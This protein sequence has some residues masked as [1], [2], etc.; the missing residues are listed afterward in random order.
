MLRTILV[1]LF[2]AVAIGGTASAQGLGFEEQF[3]L[4]EDR[5][6]LLEQLVPGTEEH[7]Y[8]TC[9]H[10]QQTGRTD[11]V[12]EL[13]QAW[14]SRYG[15]TKRFETIEMRQ[16]LLDYS[17]RPQSVL[18]ELRNRLGYSYDHTAIDPERPPVFPSKLD[19][20]TIEAGS[21]LEQELARHPN[22]VEGFTDRGLW[23]LATRRMSPQL[24][25][26]LLA[27]LMW[28]DY[29]ELVAL[30]V[31]DLK[32][33]NSPGFGSLQ[34]HG[35]LTLDQLDAAASLMPD[36]LHN[37]GFVATYLA[38]LAP[39]AG[40]D[41]RSDPIAERAYL[42]RLATFTARL[43]PSLSGLRAHALY[44][45]LDFERRSGR[46]D[47]ELLLDYLKLP[48]RADYRNPDYLKRREFGQHRTALEA[49]HEGLLEPVSNDWSLVRDCL[50]HFL[51]DD[52]GPQ[53]FAE[54]IREPI[55]RG[56]FVEA[57]VTAGSGDLER[58]YTLL[59][60]PSAFE[61]LKQRV[62]LDF[63]PS[64]RRVFRSNESVTLDLDLK[65]V[66][67]L[68]VKVY[69]INALNYYRQL[70]RELDPTISLDGLVPN[71]ERV[72][73]Y[74]EPSW[75]RVRRH[76][77]FPELAQ[78]G[79]YVIDFIGNGV[80]SRA[81]IQKGR[82]R[83]FER[84]GGAGHVFRVYD[85]LGTPVTNA[86]LWV[87]G[88]EYVANDVGDVVVPYT[89]QPGTQAI[90]A[91]RG[92]GPTALA[93]LGSF[94]HEEEE[95]SLDVDFHLDPE[96]LITDHA[97]PLLVRTRL[98]VH[99]A[100]VS[101]ERLENVQL[102]IEV[103]DLDKVSTTQ[104]IRDFELTDDELSVQTLRVPPRTTTVKV[105]LEG[106]IQSLTLGKSV[107]VN[108]HE[109]FHI[110]GIDTTAEI[111][112][113][114]FGRGPSGYR[115]E[116]RGKTGEPQ[117][118]VTVTVHLSQ[119]DI[120]KPVSVVLQSDALGFVELGE[121]LG[122]TEV[123]A[124]VPTGSASDGVWRLEDSIVTLPSTLH[125]RTA[126]VIRIPYVGRASTVS[127]IDFA[128]FELRGD[129]SPCRDQLDR[130]RLSGA[131]L[132][133]RDL[134]PGD[135]RLVMK[136]R[137]QGVLLRITDAPRTDRF[138]LSEA[139]GLE[140]SRTNA[141]QLADLSATAA[142]VV[143]QVAHPSPRTRV[144]LVARRFGHH[145]TLGR[146]LWSEVSNPEA[147][148][149]PLPESSYLTGRE[150]GDELRYILDRRRATRYP[151]NLL[152][153]PG[154]LLN[155]W[156]LRE[157]VTGRTE[158][159]AG[160]RWRQPP[161]GAKTGE[162]ER[163]IFY[164]SES[165]ARGG[166]RFSP[167]HD[168]LPEPS[169]VV[170]N[171][172]PGTDGAVRIPRSRLGTHRLVNAVVV[173]GASVIE[174]QLWLEDKPWSPKD[175]T[176]A[177]S[178]DP[179]ERFT[180]RKRI[181]AVRAGEALRIERASSAAFEIYPDLASVYRLYLTLS[182]NSTL[183][184]FSF[185]LDWPN[186][187]DDEKRAL[188]SR[189]ACHELN[190]FLW[191]KD[192]GFFTSV[193]LPTLE[194]K[195]DPTFLDRFFLGNDLTAFLDPWAY[196]Q[197]NALERAL[198]ASR[199]PGES[200]VTARHLRDLYELEPIPPQ[201]WL[202]RFRTGLQ[203][204]ALDPSQGTGYVEDS[205]VLGFGQDGTVAM[206]EEAPEGRMRRALVAPPQSPALAAKPP[207]ASAA[208]DEAD[209]ADKDLAYSKEVVR[210]YRKTPPTR[211][212]AESNY[213]HVR[214]DGAGLELI[215]ANAFWV[216]YAAHRSS[217]GP[218]LSENLAEPTGS[219]TEMLCALAVLDLPFVGARSA[220]SAVDGV[221][222]IEPTTGFVAFCQEIAPTKSTS[223]APILVGQ[224]LFRLDDRYR[225]EGSE[226]RDKFVT[227]EFIINTVYGCQVVV[228]NP[229][230]S[231]QRLDLLLQI[232]QG[233]L[234]A[235]S[236]FFTGGRFLELAPYAT[237]RV[238]YHFYFPR[239]GTFS[240]Y[241]IHVSQQGDFVTAA[242]GR[243]LNV[244]AKATQVDTD[245]WSHIS[246]QGSP[247]QV[248]RYLE[249]NNLERTDLDLIAWRLRDTASY[250]T[251]GS[252]LLELLK[253]R[254]R[255]EDSL[256]A[257]SLLHN[258]L[259]TAREFLRHEEVVLD[260]CGSWFESDLVTTN[261]V[262]QRLYEHLEYDPLVNA[263]A[264][265]LGGTRTIDNAAFFE[266][267]QRFLKQLGQKRVAADDDRLAATYYLLLQDRVDDA[268]REFALVDRERVAT[269]VQYDYVS[270]YLALFSTDAEA[271][272]AVALRHA[273]HPLVPWRERFRN[274]IDYLDEVQNVGSTQRSGRGA[275]LETNADLAE[276]EPTF[277]LRVQGQQIAIDY[278]NLS[279]CRVNYY[280]MDV[281]L[282]FSA[283]PFA[284]DSSASTDGLDPWAAIRPALSTFVELPTDRASFEFTVPAQFETSNVVVEVVAAGKRRAQARYS[285]RMSVQLAERYGQLR[286][287]RADSGSPLPS[288][289]VKVYS[290][291]SSGA[292][293]F[294]KDGYTDL[295][296]RFDYASL[297]VDELDDVQRFSILV[298]N[299]TEGAL[300]QV[301][302][303]PKQ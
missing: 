161:S 198:L 202:R 66:P 256:W 215:P 219:F 203:G 288:T 170:A 94:E 80:G 242:G 184:E 124:V 85:D 243:T 246:Q 159:K 201:D 1:M 182:S 136:E 224:N 50:L 19:P 205:K 86:R 30:I 115:L 42:E 10:A 156:S 268:L 247:Q 59:D 138:L 263:R 45:R 23:S 225:Y 257:Y 39:P 125:A 226:R 132:E 236:G 200:E 173:D 253:R 114:H 63:A 241:P 73:E 67:T 104:T 112:S 72:F 157:T 232:P 281:E 296:G 299:D 282:L 4:A 90:V 294:F 24:R 213:F 35:R 137:E 290:R 27:R 283:K 172:I 11:G 217:D 93:T 113:V 254:H 91:S 32:E 70:G 53:A 187:P 209:F 150:L 229:T 183:A 110:N 207:S 181:T 238:E 301:A 106:K 155:P 230:S 231:L 272:R 297:S 212:L 108:S 251:F 96:S 292:A 117:A 259:R 54:Y 38:R 118:G 233:A 49:G 78:P 276:R 16:L 3:A 9:L 152:A 98:L 47:R 274:V 33:P 68:L 275:G 18:E 44:H 128:L 102:K 153:R 142:D 269:Q 196:S 141:V 127:A 92:D 58:W 65:N 302:E 48:R 83:F 245:S 100:P 140:G 279:D 166:V 204:Q 208:R 7:Y 121:L 234:P 258:D 57:K 300:V 151:G 164:G 37:T 60:D 55:L 237:E 111:R 21:L 260:L 61:R 81:V 188:Y 206:E 261:P 26:A 291:N 239:P 165:G 171:L 285:S 252:S 64:N 266:Q 105:S 79:S 52:A 95:Y 25:R 160:G 286:V 287:L 31:A 264:H 162:S 29:P 46:Y 56:L 168:F 175:L 134:A 130:L 191:R 131:F 228:T 36:L 255:Y 20:R 192:P 223:S 2:G 103:T 51:A 97:A 214:N 293:R 69:E 122:V 71:H 180:E 197:L 194:H 15:R 99:G 185:V 129:S 303:P 267:Y 74:T 220:R 163:I 273:N 270:A 43:G 295:L 248:L 116:I 222:T 250:R 249:T 193:V 265:R 13:L 12:P 154:L 5:G 210:F 149:S 22:G 240:H 40:V 262:E 189:Y 178:L 34:I 135:Y 158:G 298:L 8:Y 75:R 195:K 126:D 244:V 190:L 84:R 235:L 62:D 177:K 14:Q 119:R 88:H 87:A 6:P 280:P 218:F 174:R 17:A 145:D 216:D 28:P 77:D 144:H 147:I 284:N 271:A 277:D 107:P 76:F 211:E 148:W 179:T 169:L 109:F 41:L 123:R 289:Y 221:I 101:L 143:V 278:R 167:N 199:I 89:A 227:E 139:Q 120:S 133:V 186:R 82:L 176:L 146:T